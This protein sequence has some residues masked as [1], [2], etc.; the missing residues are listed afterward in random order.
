MFI[1]VIVPVF[2][3][4]EYLIKCVESIEN[5]DFD[6]F[7]L[8][9]IDDGSTDGSAELCDK[10]ASH[11]AN[12]VVFHQ[13]NKGVSAARNLGLLKA[14]GEFIVFVDADD[15]ILPGYFSKVFD[16]RR[17]GIIKFGGLDQKK[18][19]GRVIDFPTI[20]KE[21]DFSR[22]VWQYAISSDVLRASGVTFDEGLSVGEDELFL[23]CL[24]VRSNEIMVSS[25]VYY[26]YYTRHDSAIHR[27]FTMKDAENRLVIQKKMLNYMASHSV[28]QESLFRRWVVN[29]LC[30]YYYCLFKIRIPFSACKVARKSVKDFFT[31]VDISERGWWQ[32]AY[33]FVF[34]SVFVSVVYVLIAKNVYMWVRRNV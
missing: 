14:I 30:Y 4:K 29:Q 12:I 6:D 31:S 11:Y 22:A 18:K 27:R 19:K 3:V 17:Y 9:L 7:E 2:N 24:L 13:S 26:N 8:I 23:F 16:L 33:R 1:S 25:I 34:L 15:T 32:Y 28:P 21:H 10:L 20:L 5:Q